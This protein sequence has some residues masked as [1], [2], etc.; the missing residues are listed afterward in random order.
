MSKTKY[1]NYRMIF[2][3]GKSYVGWTQK[4]LEDRKHDHYKTSFHKKRRYAVHEAILKYGFE[5]ITWEILYESEDRDFTLNIM[6]SYFIRLYGSYIEENG[7]NLTWG[8]DSP[9]LGVVQSKESKLKR[10]TS[11][12]GRRV[13]NFTPQSFIKMS[14]AH[15]AVS[16]RRIRDDKGRFIGIGL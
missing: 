1:I 15:K 4:S 9:G 16:K 13:G 12:K 11:L 10:S 3:N 7:Y 14:I 2:P 5:S 8:G 6:E